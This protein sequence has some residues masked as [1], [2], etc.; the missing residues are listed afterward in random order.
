MTWGMALSPSGDQSYNACLYIVDR[1][2]KALIFFQSNKDDTSMDTALILLN[3]IFSHTGL[4]KNIISDK[5]PKF[6]SA[7]WTIPHRLF[8]NKLSF[9]TEYHHQ[10]YC[11][12]EGDSN[13]RGDDKEILCL[14]IKAQRLRWLS[15]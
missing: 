1:Y 4:F 2:R 9:S 5:S 3:R 11:L 6:T 15:P 14:W 13:F 7:L 10:A 12:A 8:V